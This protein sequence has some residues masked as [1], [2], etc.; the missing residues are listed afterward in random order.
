MK[1]RINELHLTFKK[2]QE[3]IRFEDFSYFYGQMGAGKS[4]IARLIDFCLGGSLRTREMTPALQTEFISAGLNLTIEES[5]LQLRRNSGSNEIRASWIH[6]GD[7]LEV[8]L[9]ARK[10]DG[11]V[12]QNSGIEV[13]SDLIYVLSGRTPP[14]VRKGRIK[15]DSKLARLSLRDLLWFCYLD[16][17]SLDS[18][19]FNLEHDA[20]TFKRNKSRDVLRF[21]VGF[22]QERVSELEV[23]LEKCRLARTECESGANAMRE[24]L[25]GTD[26]ESRHELLKLQN[27]IN[28]NV[29]AL[30]AD[31]QNIRNQLEELR[32]HSVELL[33]SKARNI[34]QET[35]TLEGAISEIKTLIVADKEHRNELL[36]LSTRFRRSQAARAVLGGVKYEGCPSCGNELPPRD[37][38][39]CVVCG[40]S[41]GPSPSGALDEAAAERDLDE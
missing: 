5:H 7:H 39:V 22:Y 29:T 11:E 12:I 23:D 16:Q 24:A 15:A 33:R 20:N 31:V 14:K 4:T 34:D 32:P 36:S 25:K 21:V 37:E 9:P 30:E 35:S 10:A 18:T 38:E 19:F 1:F 26:V 41:H 13:L 2:E 8:L 28:A 40:Q 17:D 3:I 27:E 6:E